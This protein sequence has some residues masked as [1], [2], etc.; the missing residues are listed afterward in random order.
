MH[1]FCV[2]VCE[3]VSNGAESQGQVVME[4]ELFLQLIGPDERSDRGRTLFSVLLE[5]I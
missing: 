2:C 3:S 4:E 1:V 5:I